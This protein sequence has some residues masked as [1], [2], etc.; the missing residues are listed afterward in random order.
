MIVEAPRCRPQ[1]GR[2]GSAGA[3]PLHAIAM[4]RPCPLIV[5]WPVD[6]TNKPTSRSTPRTSWPWL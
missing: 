3:T 5:L 6:P 4:D 2:P 1:K